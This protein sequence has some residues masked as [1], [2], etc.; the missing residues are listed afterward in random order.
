MC[1]PLHFDVSHPINPWMSLDAQEEVGLA[2]RQWDRLREVYLGLDHRIEVIKPAEG[3]PDMVFAA[4]AGVARGGRIL[5]SNFTTPSVSRK[6]SSSCA[7]SGTPATSPLRSPR[8]PTKAK[9]T[10]WL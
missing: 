1:P 7:G 10:S 3:L 5:V 4:N 2:M 6:T 8:C 9:G